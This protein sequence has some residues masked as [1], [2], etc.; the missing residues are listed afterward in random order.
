M[1][2]SSM[3]PA[4]LGISFLATA[5]GAGDLTKVDRTIAKEPAYQNLPKYCLLVFG[6]KASLRVWLVQDGN[7]LYIDRN[8]NG[9]L[10][11]PGK[12]AG[13]T[14]SRCAAG[15]II[16]ADGKPLHTGV[17]LRKYSS[18]M[19]LSLRYEGNQ[20]YIV[21]DP[22]TEALEFGRHPSEAPVVH[23]GGPPAIE[24]IYYGLDMR[25]LALHVRVGTPGLK[26]G[27]FAG[28]VLPH[29]E[30]V[31]QILYPPKTLD[32]RPIERKITLKER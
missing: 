27:S 17:V 7:T 8:G 30:P 5:A 14:G 29:V 4:L 6:P 15:N 20:A 28:M 2:P 26:P 32:G 12:K 16:D 3:I 21:G 13:W 9:D 22:D 1:S 31:A 19:T 25:S 10:T 11:Q 18:G 24:L 23:L